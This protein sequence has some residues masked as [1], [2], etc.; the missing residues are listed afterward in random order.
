MLEF[1]VKKSYNSTIRWETTE[2]YASHAAIIT[3]WKTSDIV[4]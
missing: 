3:L 4:A 1:K 2:A